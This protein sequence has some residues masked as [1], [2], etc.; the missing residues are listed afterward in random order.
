MKKVTFLIVTV[1]VFGV[2]NLAN[3]VVPVDKKKASHGLNIEIPTHAMIALAG[4]SSKEIDFEANAAD[5]AGDKVS[6]SQK[7]ETTLWLNY[8]S[9]V[10][11]DNSNTISAEITDV[12][13]GLT[14]EVAVSNAASGNK[15]GHTGKGYKKALTTDGVQ[16]V[17]DIKTCYTG[18]GENNGHELVYS[19]SA[20]ESKYDEIVADSHHLTVTYTITEK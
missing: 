6:F 10:T 3:A 20:D 17:D 5:V 2:A 18:T 9:L 16:V 14:I 11:E 12:P 8:S 1:L 7:N 19:V 4:P 15:K 13:D